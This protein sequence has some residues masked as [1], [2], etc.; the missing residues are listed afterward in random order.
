MSWTQ[1]FINISYNRSSTFNTWLFSIRV[2]RNFLQFI[3]LTIFCSN[4][5][6]SIVRS[7]VFSIYWCICYVDYC[8]SYFF[9]F[10]GNTW[11]R[12]SRLV[13]IKNYYTSVITFCF[14]FF[15]FFVNIS[16][17]LWLFTYF[18]FFLSRSCFSLFFKKIYFTI[19]FDTF[20]F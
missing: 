14:W 6:W 8:T 2:F 3:N 1:H 18:T 16:N 7:I 20:W 13:S 5:L 17:I 12:T 4:S 15:Y 10:I 11:D 9:T 19:F